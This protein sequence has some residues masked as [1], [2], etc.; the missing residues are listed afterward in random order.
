MHKYIHICVCVYVYVF[1]VV[2]VVKSPTASAG[3][4]RDAGLIPGSGRSLEGWNGNPLQ[5]SGL[6]NPMDRGAWRA[7]VHRAAKNWT[8]L[9]QLS[10]CMH[11][12][13]HTRTHTQRWWHSGKESVWQ[14]MPEMQVWSLGWE[15]SLEQEMATHSGIL[16]WKFP[17]TEEPGR[18]QTMGWQ[19]VGHN[20]AHICTLDKRKWGGWYLVL[21]RKGKELGI[22]MGLNVNLNW[23]VRECLTAKG[24]FG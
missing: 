18:L 24:T 23:I 5:Y 9:K 4:I 15:E 10:T 14:D 12:H 22:L 16:A 13:T 2:L 8:W 17:W 3:D 20:W 19:R 1:Q 11:T 21:W 6:G 7:I